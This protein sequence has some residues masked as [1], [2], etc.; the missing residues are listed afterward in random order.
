MTKCSQLALYNRIF[1]GEFRIRVVVWAT[2]AVV[3][4]SAL[5]FIFVF[6][7]MC[8][9]IRQQWTIDRVGHCKDQISVL[10]WLITVNFVTDVAV[11]CIPLRRVWKLQMCM[12]E[13]VTI[14]LCFALGLGCCFIGIARFALIFTVGA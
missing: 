13:K 3:L 5:S 2:L 14:V 12:T 4:A 9:P 7:F 11:V 10:K 1:D 6:I 8:D